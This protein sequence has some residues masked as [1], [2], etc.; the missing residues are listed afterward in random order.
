MSKGLKPQDILKWLLV[1]SGVLFSWFLFRTF[2][3]LYENIAMSF[4][5]NIPIE[6]G[7]LIITLLLIIILSYILR[8]QINIRRFLRLK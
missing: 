7:G 4:F 6:I 2:V 8:K 3:L 5:P 1:L